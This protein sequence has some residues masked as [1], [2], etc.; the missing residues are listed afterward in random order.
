MEKE[1]VSDDS[2][3]FFLERLSRGKY[4]S[5]IDY[6]NAFKYITKM[7]YGYSLLAL[8]VHWHP[9]IR[10]K[11]LLNLNQKLTIRPLVNSVKM[12]NGEWKKYDKIAIEFLI[13]TLE[14]STLFMTGSENATIHSIYISNILWNLDLLTQENIVEKKQFRDW[15]KNDLQ[16]EHAVLK[17]KAHVK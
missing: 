10:V 2:V 4:K 14:S 7:D 11:A 6:E 13:H 9:D 5:A 17:W 12:K 8:S 15:Y 16:F 3:K 1:I